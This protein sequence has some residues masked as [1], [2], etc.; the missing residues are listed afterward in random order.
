MDLGTF[1]VDTIVV[2]DVPARRADG[3]GDPVILSEIPSALD[4]GL[5]NFFK[6]RITRSLQRQAFEVEHNPD[7]KSP[8]PDLITQ[9]LNHD[10]KL[11]RSSQDIARHLHASQTG[12][13]PSGLVVICR[14]TVDG[15]DCCAILKLEREDALRIEVTGAD[16][17]RTFNVAYLKDLMLGQNTRVFKASLFTVSDGTAAGLE[18]L[19][20]DDQSTVTD[21][22]GGIASF[23]LQKFLGCRLKEAPAIATRKFFESTQDWINT[24][25]DPIKRGRYEV[26]L[27]ASMNSQS[28]FVVPKTFADQNLDQSDRP[29]YRKYLADTAAPV[30][31]FPKDVGLIAPKIR[32]MSISFE[33]SSVRVSGKPDDINDYVKINRPDGGAAPVEIHDHVKDVRGGR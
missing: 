16:G 23:F 3:S 11:V 19:V 18:G 20:S 33:K 1:F 24:V 12:N 10:K 2:H 30:S 8:V 14:G 5:R 13:N 22:S 26:A 15:N 6:E 25:T 32:Q 9:I 31:R 7:E 17:K 21:L 27:I 29:P 28:R 4:A